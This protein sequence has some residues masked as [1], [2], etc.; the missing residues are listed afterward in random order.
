MFNF[1]RCQIVDDKVVAENA[2]RNITPSADRHN[3]YPVNYPE[4]LTI[5]ARLLEF[6]IMLPHDNISHLNFSLAGKVMANT[7][8]QEI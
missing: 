4:F 6:L 5:Q 2:G 1:Y 7:H 3:L 8:I